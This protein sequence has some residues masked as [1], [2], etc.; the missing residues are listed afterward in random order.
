MSAATRKQRRHRRN[1]RDG[2]TA[3]LAALFGAR[4]SVSNSFGDD[5]DQLINR[6]C[7]LFMSEHNV[8]NP[9]RYMLLHKLQL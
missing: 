1:P 7:L 4:R 3:S 6:L 2:E 9:R 5:V 8:F